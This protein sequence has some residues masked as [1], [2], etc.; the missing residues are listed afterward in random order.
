MSRGLMAGLV[1][2]DNLPMGATCKHRSP[3]FRALS[4]FR[5]HPLQV[6]RPLLGGLSVSDDLLGD[7]PGPWEREARADWYP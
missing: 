6:T 5:I 2:S 4:Y 3:M 1:V 7:V